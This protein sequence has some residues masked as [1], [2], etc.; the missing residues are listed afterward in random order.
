MSI[1]AHCALN[2]QNP[3]ILHHNTKAMSIQKNPKKRNLRL[4]VYT[5]LFQ[6]IPY[7]KYKQQQVHAI[8][9]LLFAIHLPLVAPGNVSTDNCGNTFI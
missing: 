5:V 1:G 7:Q 2:I 6:N 8:L 4:S 9:P 3:A